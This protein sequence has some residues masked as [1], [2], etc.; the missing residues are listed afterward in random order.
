MPIN[1]PSEADPHSERAA[2]VPDNMIQRVTDKLT[3]GQPYTTEADDIRELLAHCQHEAI[4]SWDYWLDDIGREEAKIAFEDDSY[5]ILDLGSRTRPSD[6]L[7]S[8]DG[9]ISVDE[10]KENIVTAVHRALARGLTNEMWSDTYPYVVRK[11][12]LWE[13]VEEHVVRRIGALTRERGSVGRGTDSFAVDIQGQKQKFW[14]NRTDRTRQ[15]VNNNLNRGKQEA[16]SE[17]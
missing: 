13:L 5:I 2:F 3:E 6:Y 17:D 15:A 10:T 1:Y 8:Y 9:S 4:Q 11:P 12:P 14:A 7:E 16:A